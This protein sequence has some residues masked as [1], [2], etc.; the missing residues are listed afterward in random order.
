MTFLVGLNREFDEVSG[1]LLGT[2]PL[3]SIDDVFAEVR[4]V[5]HYRCVMPCESPS[6][7]LESSAMAAYFNCPASQKKTL[8]YDHCNKSYH[9]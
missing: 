1:W 7:L 8:W 5:E 2:H 9:T 3:P 6:L 4:R